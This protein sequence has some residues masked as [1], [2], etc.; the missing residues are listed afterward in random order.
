MKQQLTQTVG[1]ID[2]CFLFLLSSKAKVSL[3]LLMVF[4]YCFFW[5][6]IRQYFNR[7]FLAMKDITNMA[8]KIKIYLGIMV[9]SGISMWVIGNE[10]AEIRE[11]PSHRE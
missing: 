9:M 10:T 5:Q 6:M 11:L 1:L 4:Y 3:L 8:S 7:V 2:N